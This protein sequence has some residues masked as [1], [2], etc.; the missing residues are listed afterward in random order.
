MLYNIWNKWLDVEPFHRANPGLTRPGWWLD[1][2]P[3]KGLVSMAPTKPAMVDVP[4]RLSRWYNGGKQTDLTIRANTPF[5]PHP[6]CL[7]LSC[8]VLGRSTKVLGNIKVPPPLNFTFIL[9]SLKIFNKGLILPRPL[10]LLHSLKIF[11]K[12][13]ILPPPINF[14]IHWRSSIKI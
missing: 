1:G 3:T 8:L 7:V 9:D 12:D 10:K 14:Y 13:L 4:E 6:S 11:N 2:S 5:R